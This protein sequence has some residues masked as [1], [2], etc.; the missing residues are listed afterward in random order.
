MNCDQVFDILTR[1][2]FPTGDRSDRAV[3]FHLAECPE[4]QRLANALRPAIELFQEAISGDEGR[5]LPGYWG[6]MIDES[7]EFQPAGRLTQGTRR[8]PA[9]LHRRIDSGRRWVSAQTGGNGL[10]FVAAMLVGVALGA[11]VWTAGVPAKESWSDSNKLASAGRTSDD[12]RAEMHESSSSNPP[13]W[14]SVK[15]AL[16]TADV[17]I[18]LQ[19]AAAC[20]TSDPG[21]SAETPEFGRQIAVL[22]VADLARQHCCTRCHHAL[23]DKTHPRATAAVA[24]SCE[25]CHR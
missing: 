24:H 17:R 11:V 3:E 14:T 7:E 2:P 6:G 10:R 18:T 8:L 21:F 20:L 4:C 25:I 12:H 19:L 5:E 13:G 9:A 16:S 22:S 23:A 1:G 15:P